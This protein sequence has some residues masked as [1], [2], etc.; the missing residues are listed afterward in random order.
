MNYI[1]CSLYIPP[2]SPLSLYEEHTIN[3]AFICDNFPKANIIVIGDFNLRNFTKSVATI[4]HS[5]RNL[6]GNSNY[7]NMLN[8]STDKILL[9]S[10]SCE[11]TIFDSACLYDLVQFNSVGNIDGLILDLVFSNCPEIIVRRSTSPLATIDDLHPPLDII[12]RCDAM[13][14]V[15]VPITENS[16]NFRKADYDLLNDCFGSIDWNILYSHANDVDMA[17]E[18]FYS[19]LYAAIE[20][21]VP[22]KPISSIKYPFFYSSKTI[23]LIKQKNNLINLTILFFILT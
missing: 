7:M 8:Y 18:I 15:A 5:D 10:D 17:L 23:N 6:D 21:Y 12:I 1:I 22:I 11:M 14:D 9:L 19:I 13:N 16:F 3:L 20:L 2:S 4:D